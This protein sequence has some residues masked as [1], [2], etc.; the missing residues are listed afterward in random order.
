MGAPAE[1]ATVASPGDQAQA[2]ANT[3]VHAF[4]L[5]PPGPLRRSPALRRFLD[6]QA[7]RFD[8]VHVHALWQ[9]PC[10]YGRQ[11]ALRHGR[12]LLISPR[13][14][15]EPWALQQ[16]AWLKRFALATWEGRNL[17]AAAAFHATSEAEA[18]RLHARGLA[19]LCTVIP[20]GIH[21][22]LLKA[23][24][25]EDGTRSLLFLSRFH[26]VKGGD[27]LIRAW[28][29]LHG[30]FP[31]WRLDLVGP[32][33]GGV[34]AQWEAL[35]ATLR[36]PAPAIRFGDAV[37][38]PAK[39][40]LLAAADLFVLPSHSENFGNVVLEALAAGAPVI[41]TRGTPWQGLEARHCGW[42]IPLE[43]DA[44]EATLRAALS[45]PDAERRAMGDR[46]RAWSEA[47]QWPAIAA[48]MA[49]AY[50]RVLTGWNGRPIA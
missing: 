11:A 29:R 28:A 30:A 26:P 31:D 6:A 10:V 1:I 35:A 21:L 9:T 20:N 14:M 36:I 49:A 50:D 3:P 13:G 4:P 2:P 45:L 16:R 32:D 48:A 15:L 17:R 47:F 18:S 24:R 27:L 41:A 7:G 38:G 8:L 34:R 12:P 39:W 5:A 19:Q 37:A 23:G 42:W 44:L 43:V 33:E 25:R 46:G 40:D 22:P